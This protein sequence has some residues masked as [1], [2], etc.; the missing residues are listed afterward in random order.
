MSK[1]LVPLVI[2]FSI[3]M[4][5]FIIL[6]FIGGGIGSLDPEFQIR[7]FPLMLL[8]FSPLVIGTSARLYL[9]PKTKSESEFLVALIISLALCEG[10]GLISLFTF[11][12]EMTTEKAFA[13]MTAILGVA[14]LCPLGITRSSRD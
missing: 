8:G 12:S 1:I 4:G 14:L 3:L 5:L 10:V 2:W 13:Y 7:S 6:I 11:P 9:L